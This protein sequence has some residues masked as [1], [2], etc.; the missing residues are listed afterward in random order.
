MASKRTIVIKLCLFLHILEVL[1][2]IVLTVFSFLLENAADV[3]LAETASWL[4]IPCALFGLVGIVIIVLNKLKEEL[5]F[6]LVFH[7]LVITLSIICLILVAPKVVRWE[8]VSSYQTSGKCHQLKGSCNCTVPLPTT[9]YKCVDL[10]GIYDLALIIAVIVG[11]CLA[12]GVLAAYF[13]FLIISKYVPKDNH[14]QN[15]NQTKKGVYD[16]EHLVDLSEDIGHI[17]PLN[18][19]DLV[20][21]LDDEIPSRVIS[22]EWNRCSEAEVPLE[23]VMQEVERYSMGSAASLPVC[24]SAGDPKPE[25]LDKKS[26]PSSMPNSVTGSKQSIRSR[27]DTLL[28]R[29]Q[30]VQAR[31]QNDENGGEDDQDDALLNELEKNS[32]SSSAGQLDGN[33]SPINGNNIHESNNQAKNPVKSASRNATGAE[34]GGD[35]SPRTSTQK[36]DSKRSCSESNFNQKN[37]KGQSQKVEAQRSLSEGN[38]VDEVRRNSRIRSLGQI[39][40]TDST[41]LKDA[42]KSGEED[43]LAQ[44][45]AISQSPSRRSGYANR[46]FYGLPPIPLKELKADLSIQE[47]TFSAPSL[48]YF[49]LNTKETITL[50]RAIRPGSS[51]SQVLARDKRRDLPQTRNNLIDDELLVH[52]TSNLYEKQDSISEQDDEP[53]RRN[54]FETVSTDIDIDDGAN[55]SEASDEQGKKPRWHPPWQLKQEIIAHKESIPVLA[56][57]PRNRWFASGSADKTIKIWDLNNG[58]C[59][60]TVKGHKAGVRALTF[61][62]SGHRFI[63]SAADDRQLLCTDIEVNRIVTHYPDQSSVIYA[64]GMYRQAELLVTC[65]RDKYVKIWDTR[66][67]KCIKTMRGHMNSVSSIAILENSGQIVSGSHDST[68]RIWDIGEGRCTQILTGHEKSVRSIVIHPEEPVISSASTERIIHWSM[69]D[70]EKMKEIT[71]QDIS[72]NCISVNPQGALVAAGSN[73][74]IH[75]WDWKSGHKFQKIHRTRVYESQEVPICVFSTVFD[76]SGS[77]LLVSDASNI[78]KVYGEAYTR[79]RRRFNVPEEKKQRRTTSSGRMTGNNAFS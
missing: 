36:A 66:E 62:S 70:G 75:L 76:K 21:K 12:I 8:P 67:K 44:G 34:E 61:G 28:R 48:P 15:S 78:I 51:G 42:F 13:D 31:N 60:L 27:K 69:P 71:P 4:G 40:P 57:E 58:N 65:G 2:G 3:S 1:L 53:R 17:G 33:A 23:E 63:Y 7:G 39:K 54:S 29:L 20:P 68:M 32:R 26:R 55:I 43:E 45:N 18:T 38:V 30:T 6:V 24:H 52:Q 74:V 49:D 56:I 35:V 22:V 14:M 37:I 73:G 9:V 59:R 10:A 41:E 25:Q 16:Q 11:L 77:R 64:M 79:V 50:P 5:V 47:R 46:E 72:I 19:P